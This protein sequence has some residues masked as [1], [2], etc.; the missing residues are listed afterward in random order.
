[1]K[2]PN[3]CITKR[4]GTIAVLI[5][6]VFGA[7]V[8]LLATGS[9]TPLFKDAG[10]IADWV[11]ASGTWV[12]GYGA[13][14]YAKVSHDH[15]IHEYRQ[16]ELRR[17][18]EGVLRGA[19]MLENA[20][21]VSTL[22]GWLRETK[23]QDPDGGVSDAM[24]SCRVSLALLETLNSRPEDLMLLSPKGLA[25]HG[26]LGRTVTRMKDTLRRSLAI[27]E[28]ATPSSQAVIGELVLLGVDA[29]ADAAEFAEHVNKAISELTLERE[30]V[31]R[32][33]FEEIK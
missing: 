23:T 3:G 27:L 10:S 2:I 13:W 24:S 30:R 12:I 21:L 15:R 26:K 5:A 6:A 18:K 25:A 11:A 16:G 28:A 22:G 1:M 20:A 4:D 33:L 19:A 31:N 32:A 8:A 14:K 17:I 9:T 29:E 7:G